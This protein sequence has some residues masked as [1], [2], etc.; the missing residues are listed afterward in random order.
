VLVELLDL[1]FANRVRGWM[2]SECQIRS[3]RAARIF[4]KLAVLQ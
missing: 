1:T 2:D 3:T 4:S